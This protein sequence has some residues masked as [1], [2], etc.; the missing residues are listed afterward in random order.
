MPPLDQARRSVELQRQRQCG[1]PLTRSD[2][3]GV[4]T[5]NDATGREGGTDSLRASSVEGVAAAT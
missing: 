3:P 4:D 1:Q 2:D 5:R